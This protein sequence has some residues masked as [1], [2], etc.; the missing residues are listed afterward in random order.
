MIT[1]RTAQDQD[2]KELSRLCLQLGYPCSPEECRKYFRQLESDPDHIV[3]VAES[4]EGKITGYIHVFITKRLFLDP[5]VEI[6]GLVVDDK[7]RGKGVGKALLDYSEKWLIKQGCRE[8]RV[9]SNV[10]REEAH[11]FY[12]NQGYLINKQQKVFLKEFS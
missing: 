12:L 2:F 1:I 3:Y 11:Q 9:R 6:G 7:F 5:F 10:I 4:G 8:M